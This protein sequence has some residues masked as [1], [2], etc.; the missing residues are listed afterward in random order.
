MII[1]LPQISLPI[2][3]YPHSHE[4]IFD[5]LLN[6]EDA[7]IRETTLEIFH[8]FQMHFI[9]NE[10]HVFF[11]SMQEQ[12]AGINSEESGDEELMHGLRFLTHV[13]I[14]MRHMELD[15]DNPS[16]NFIIQRYIELLQLE[17]KH[18]LIA[19]FYEF[20]PKDDQVHGYSSFLSSIQDNKSYYYQL[21]LDHGLDMLQIS[22][23]TVSICSRPILEQDLPLDIP[24]IEMS[25]LESEM[26]ESDIVLINSLEWLGFEDHQIPFLIDF[27]NAIMRR[28]LS[29]F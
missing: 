27:S 9:M 14:L 23:R 3:S 2:P 11:A 12:L 5:K 22:E 29:T 16:T 15:V 21:G 4:T 19:L 10:V 28:Y 7:N 20:L 13:I 18:D 25:D 26:E 6:H 17:G 1:Q 24:S 8:S